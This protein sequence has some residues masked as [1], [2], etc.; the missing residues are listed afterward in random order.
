M[1]WLL[2]LVA[3]AFETGFAVL[4]K[5]SHGITRAWPTAG[6]AMAR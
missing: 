2:V 1:A 3:G 4:L 6:F 5:Q